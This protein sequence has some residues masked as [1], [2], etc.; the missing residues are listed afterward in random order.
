MAAEPWFTVGPTDV[1]PEEFASFLGVSGELR[2]AFMD[3][4]SDL[5]RPD[6]WTST[7][8]RVETGELIEIYPYEGGARLEP[9][10]LGGDT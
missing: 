8:S 2:T 10:A 6:W 9:A 3:N 5:F 4:H 7:Q 1:F